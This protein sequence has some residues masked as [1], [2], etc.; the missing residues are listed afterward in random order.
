M[1]TVV[2]YGC[3][4]YPFEDLFHFRHGRHQEA[5]DS[6][7]PIQEALLG[8]AKAVRFREP[9][10]VYQRELLGL[11]R[12]HGLC[13]IPLTLRQRLERSVQVSY[14]ELLLLPLNLL[15]SLLGRRRRLLL[16][17]HQLSYLRILLGHLL[18]EL[19]I[20]LLTLL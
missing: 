4:P 9:F 14:R 10:R 17:L 19:G 16:R 6:C 11:L 5:F 20:L 1:I 12:F 3:E 13:E 2:D 18:L 8:P 7:T 15:N